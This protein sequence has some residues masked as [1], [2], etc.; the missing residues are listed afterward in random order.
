LVVASG[1][2]GVGVFATSTNT[3]ATVDNISVREIPGNHATS[4]GT[5]RPKLAARYNLLTY[6]EQFDH[7]IWTKNNV[8]VTANT[9]VAPN[10]AT[11]A[12]SLI[13][14]GTND[15][16]RISQTAAVTSGAAYTIFV[17]VRKANVRYFQLVGS[18][19]TFFP[20]GNGAWFDL[21][22]GI[23]SPG[24]STAA[25][26]TAVGNGWYLCSITMTAVGTG[27]SS[28]FF[29]PSDNNSSP[30][31]QGVN[32]RTSVYL[33]GADLRPAS[34][35]TGLIGPTYQRVVDAATYDTAGFLPYLQ[36]DGIDDSMSTNSIDFSAGDKMTVWAG[37]RKLSD[38]TTG[39]VF[40]TS[41]TYSGN[42]GSFA[43]FSAYAANTHAVT[44]RGS[45]GNGEAVV[46]TFT[47]PITNVVS[48]SINLALNIVSSVLNVRVNG[49]VPST[50]YTPTPSSAMGVGN[51][52]NYSLFIGQ[53]NNTNFP[54]NGWL[55]SLIIRGA[56]STDSQISA[57]ESWVNGRTGA[58]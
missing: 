41:A 1:V 11:T 18:S 43:L 28:F 20:T 26:M 24:T 39:T 58:Y 36:F 48:G 33:W 22:T 56:Q 9:V 53:R 25:T 35:A 30:T 21:D 37:V 10:G 12:D 49:V 31:Y 3:V 52:G 8:T 13:E 54:F 32:G 57:T 16:H 51:F 47:A 50:A 42:N 27:T 4:T 29:N 14:D 23:A 19:P 5:K 7:A 44:A 15:V 40:E 34:Q 17:Y 2:G 45:T 6:T 38:A 46:S 55:S